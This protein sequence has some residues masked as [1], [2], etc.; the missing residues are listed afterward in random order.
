M[1]PKCLKDRGKNVSG[2][3]RWLSRLNLGLGFWLR[4]RSQGHEMKPHVGL[5]AGLEPTLKKSAK[6]TFEKKNQEWKIC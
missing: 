4:S 6:N 5:H 1:P 2:V 3:P